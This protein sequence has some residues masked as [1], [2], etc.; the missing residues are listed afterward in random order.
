M[1]QL[2]REGLLSGA[3][4]GGY[5]EKWIRNTIENG[6]ALNTVIDIARDHDIRP[7]D[8]D[9]LN[10]QKEIKDPEGK[11][12]FL[13]DSDLS[14]DD[15]RKAVLMT[16]I[17]NAGTDYPGKPVGDF[18]ATPYSSNEVRRIIERQEDNDWSY[19]DDVG[20]VHGNGGRLVTTPNG[21]IMGAGGNELQ[22]LYSFKGGTCYG[23]IFMINEDDLDTPTGD[24]RRSSSPV[25][26]RPVVST[27][28]GSCT[29]RSG[30]RSSGPSTVT[31][32][33]CG[34]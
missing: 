2:R 16:Y 3:D 9:V 18:P 7:D 19:D 23:D 11:S 33:C 29:T 24:S 8:F 28:T 30:T 14:G 13:L 17:L 27:S 5:Y 32:A 12:F 1:E 26:V 10:G 21:M 22:D 31:P 25:S 34:G 4:P 20:F 6:V 15:A